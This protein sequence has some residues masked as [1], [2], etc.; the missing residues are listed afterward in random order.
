MSL[1]RRRLLELTLG[2]GQLALLGRM[3]GTRP[4]HAQATV[5]RPTRMLA[6]WIDGGLHWE[7]FFTPLSRMGVQKYIPA[8]SGGVIP[9]GYLPEQVQ[10]F[11]RSPADLDAPGPSRP[12]R[13]PIYWNWDDPGDARGSI[14][15]SGNTQNYR[16][17]GYAWADPMYRLYERTAVLVGAD[18]GTASHYSGIVASLCGI[19]GSNFR[20]PAIQAVIANHLSRRFPDRPLGNVSLGGP[21]PSSLELPSVASPTVVSSAASLEP[22][23][24]DHRDGAWRGLRARSDVPDVGFD[25]AARA[26]VVPAT[27]TDAAVLAAIRAR[28]G[29][30]TTGTDALLSRLYDNTQS[31][32]KTLARDVVRT[33][34]A[35]QGYQYLSANPRYPRDWTACIGYA[36]A[37][38]SGAS[39][40]N[41]ELA[42][43]LLKSE[44]ATCV[45]LRGTSFNNFSFDTH[46][47]NG[48]QI[49]TN[50]LH[51]AFEQIGRLLLE[52]SLTPISGGRT[53]LDDT[54]VYV[55]SDFGRTFPKT[56]SDHHPATC[57]VLAGGGIRGNQLVGGYDETMDGSPMGAPV[58]LLEESGARVTRA[59]RSQDIAATVIS[60]FGLESGRDYFLPGGYG[61]FD[62][63]LG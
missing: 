16:P 55:Y 13:G 58:P 21:L 29:Q 15:T 50:H 10:N 4:A 34:D 1:T 40:G 9:V 24:S 36:D 28:R 47:A 17:W 19:A 2:A 26:G 7:T 44:L 48:V 56:G 49:H 61:V 5:D 32:S 31:A 14:A 12:L 35:T 27:A 8:P 30:S 41:Y 45:T 23:L 52:M 46:T 53:L 25:G 11:D 62:G 57:A 63:V 3:G 43:R 20:A 18:Q 54:L 33:L 51:I 37:C 60:A 39:M 38:G 42:L 6:I 59:P 22:T